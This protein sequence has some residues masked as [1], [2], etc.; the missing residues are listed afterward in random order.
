MSIK[1]NKVIIPNDYKEIIFNETNGKSFV[2][3]NANVMLVSLKSAIPINLVNLDLSPKMSYVAEVSYKCEYASY[4]EMYGDSNGNRIYKTLKFNIFIDSNT[5]SKYRFFRFSLSPNVDIYNNTQYLT[6]GT[7]TNTGSA[8]VIS[9]ASP[10]GVKM[11]LNITIMDSAVILF[12]K[13]FER[14]LI[15]N[16]GVLEYG[17]GILMGGSSSASVYF[18]TFNFVF[19]SLNGTMTDETPDIFGSFISTLPKA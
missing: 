1:P 14:S 10:M 12:T 9:K 13:T 5:A 17:Q 4:S 7:D 11:Q 18:K 6:G 19:D 15:E 2:S 16:E 8:T 3:D